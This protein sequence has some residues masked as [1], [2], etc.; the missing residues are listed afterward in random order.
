MLTSACCSDPV[1]GRSTPA[2]GW[3]LVVELSL[4]GK[5][6]SQLSG[7]SGMATG[8]SPVTLTPCVIPSTVIPGTLPPSLV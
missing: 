3:M 6:C 4:I 1:E 2:L 5:V 8:S 7:S